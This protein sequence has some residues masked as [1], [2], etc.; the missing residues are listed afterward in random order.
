MFSFY[1]NITSH[2]RNLISENLK[3]EFLSEGFGHNEQMFS[4][5]QAKK[6]PQK[7]TLEIRD[8]MS[9]NKWCWFYHVTIETPEHRLFVLREESFPSCNLVITQECTADTRHMT[10]S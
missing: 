8:K 2:Y 5:Q 3:D 4:N 9:E 1:S 6:N 7:T 10:G